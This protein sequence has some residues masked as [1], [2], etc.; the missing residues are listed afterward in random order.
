MSTM[1][2]R[3]HRVQDTSPDETTVVALSEWNRRPDLPDGARMLCREPGH[4]AM[5][6]LHQPGA[7]GRIH[8]Q[9]AACTETQPVTTDQVVVALGSERLPVA[10]VEDHGD[11]VQMPPDMLGDRGDGTVR[12]SVIA[13][14]S[15]VSMTGL[16]VVGLA[17]GFFA[18]GALASVLLHGAGGV[19]LAT[20]VIALVG[21]AAGETISHRRYPVARVT[22]STPTKAAA[23]QTGDW[24]PVRPGPGPHNGATRVVQVSGLALNHRRYPGVRVTLLNGQA[25]DCH[26]DD[27]WCVLALR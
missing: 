10:P 3:Q 7:S 19:L 18:G 20:I 6:V 16:G 1:D 5:V 22:A 12:L 2:E 9:C 15:G 8:W 4:G 21:G 13:Q 23:L 27:T 17:L 14:H 25:I 11:Q 26:G 24:V